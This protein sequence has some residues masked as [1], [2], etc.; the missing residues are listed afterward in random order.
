VNL[1][2][3]TTSFTIGDLAWRALFFT[4]PY[5]INIIITSKRTMI[6]SLQMMRMRFT[7]VG[8][9]EFENPIALVSNK[10]RINSDILSKRVMAWGGP[11]ID[12]GVGVQFGH[13]LRA[14]V[15]RLL[16][17]AFTRYVGCGDEIE[18]VVDFADV[19]SIHINKYVVSPKFAYLSIPGKYAEPAAFNNAQMTAWINAQAKGADRPLRRA[20]FNWAVNL[21]FLAPRATYSYRLLS[22]A[23]IQRGFADEGVPFIKP[24]IVLDESLVLQIDEPGMHLAFETPFTGT[25]VDAFGYAQPPGRIHSNELHYGADWWSDIPLHIN[26]PFT[27]I[28]LLRVTERLPMRRPFAFFFPLWEDAEFMTLLST[29]P[30]YATKTILH[31]PDAKMRQD[32][33]TPRFGMVHY[34]PQ[35]PKRHRGFILKASGAGGSFWVKMDPSRRIDYDKFASDEVGWNV[36]APFDDPAWWRVPSRIPGVYRHFSKAVLGYDGTKIMTGVIPWEVLHE[37]TTPDDILTFVAVPKADIERNARAKRE[38]FLKEGRTPYQPTNSEEMFAWQVEMAAEARRRNIPI[39][40]SFDEAEAYI[41]ERRTPPPLSQ[42][43]EESLML[44]VRSRWPGNVHIGSIR[45]Y[46]GERHLVYPITSMTLRGS[47]FVPYTGAR[48]AVLYNADLIVA[49][50][51]SYSPA[52]PFDDNEQSRRL[53]EVVIIKRDI[54]SYRYAIGDLPAA[55]FSVSNASNKR[56]LVFSMLET[57]PHFIA[58]VPNSGARNWWPPGFNSITFDDAYMTVTGPQLFKDWTY[59]PDEF[60]DYNVYSIAD[61]L[62]AMSVTGEPGREKYLSLGVAWDASHPFND[63][64]FVVTKGITLFDTSRQTWINS[65][66]Q[67]IKTLSILLRTIFGLNDSSLHEARF[68]VVSDLIPITPVEGFEITGSVTFHGASI[69][70]N[71]AG[72]LIN[73]LLWSHFGVVDFRRYLDTIEDNSFVHFMKR[74]ISS[75]VVVEP[76]RSPRSLWHGYLDW[77]LALA[78]YRWYCKE[79]NLQYKVDTVKYILQRLDRISAAADG[80]RVSEGWHGSRH[81]ESAGDPPPIEDCREN[82][83]D[84]RASLTR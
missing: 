61:F 5:D 60:L 56:E 32:K 46:K 26:P 81:R 19:N 14:A 50:E 40:G 36:A 47:Y 71:V 82:I 70:I 58:V 75:F 25:V 68:R 10:Q 2:P 48:W 13:I 55:I 69:Y 18:S 57:L 76:V 44:P 29:M 74:D 3:L 34:T 45:T 33:T 62:T 73:M 30:F 16:Q 27:A 64:W 39:F 54:A 20:L 15:K 22:F 7:I 9:R 77:L 1:D 53:G 35:I 24:E 21:D 41:M 28:I 6:T 38:Q 63:A 80:F 66:T 65:Q 78:C 84:L 42:K 51:L 17:G 59:S 79:L 11:L 37:Q 43:A 4:W 31:H 72:H 12:G 83:V 8:D 23:D 49:N 67:Y 52:T